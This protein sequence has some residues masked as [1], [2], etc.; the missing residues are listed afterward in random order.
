MA[1]ANLHTWL[2][3]GPNVPQ[4][5]GIEPMS[6]DQTTCVGRGTSTLSPLPPLS[7]FSSHIDH[8]QFEE[9]SSPLIHGSYA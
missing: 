5:S 8:Y 7:N 3:L 4:E 1:S 9:S 6:H 2:C